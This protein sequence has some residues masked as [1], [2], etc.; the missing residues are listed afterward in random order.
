MPIFSVLMLATFW[1][2][3]FV[4]IQAIVHDAPPIA[5]AMWRV[6]IATILTFIFSK[7][8]RITPPPHYRRH[9]M[10][11]GLLSMG[12]PWALLFWTE[13]HINGALGA[14][15]N[16]TVPIGVLILN[17]LFNR[18]TRI[19]HQQWLGI[20]TSLTGIVVIFGPKLIQGPASDGW[21]I[22]ALVGMVTG[23]AISVSYTHRYLKN[24]PAA[25]V[26]GWQGVSAGAFLFIVAVITGEPVASPV[27]WQVKTVWMG[28]LYLAI[29]ST[30]IANMVFVSLIQSKGSVV[31]SLVTFLIPIVSL[32][33][34]WIWLG[35]APSR[36]SVVGLI[37]VLGGLYIVQF[38]KSRRLRRPPIA[39]STEQPVLGE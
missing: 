30:F 18:S 22:M 14:I 7:A 6:V 20:L 16:A 39:T 21:A 37:L 32:V 33:V 9:A 24:V 5:A 31:A 23:Y 34:E 8:R 4:A 36:S 12:I 19:Q 2:G 29:C 26:A 13:Q 10:I 35:S 15:M 17:P 28:I 38:Y 27:F 25:A 3:S 1:G 11:C